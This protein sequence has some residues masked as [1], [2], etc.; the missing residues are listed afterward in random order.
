MHHRHAKTEGSRWLRSVGL[1]A[2]SAVLVLSL[3]VVVAA[4]GGSTTTGAIPGARPAAS[5]GNPT[6]TTVTVPAPSVSGPSS[7]PLS[8]QSLSSIGT[9]LGVLDQNLAQ[10]DGDNT[11]SAQKDS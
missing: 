10:I 1:R 11:V 9:Q 4:C 5:A 2:M 8:T 6:T 3:P 7:D